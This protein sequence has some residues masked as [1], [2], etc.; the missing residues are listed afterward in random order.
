MTKMK[1][2]LAVMGRTMEDE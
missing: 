1:L 2:G